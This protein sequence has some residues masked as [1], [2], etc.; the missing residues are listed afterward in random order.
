MIFHS[1]EI[2][3]IPYFCRKLGIK[4]QNLLPSGVVIG[5][6]KVKMNIYYCP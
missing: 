5:A 2:L 3:I 6:L 4:L 1:H